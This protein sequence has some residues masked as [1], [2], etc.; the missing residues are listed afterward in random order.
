MHGSEGFGWSYGA[1]ALAFT[2]QWILSGA[3]SPAV[4]WLG[5]R[6]GVHRVMGLGAVLFTGGM[7]LTGAMTHLWQFLFYF[8]VILGAS[9]AIFQVS[10]ITGVTLWFRTHLGIAIGALQG[11]QGFGTVMALLLSLIH[12]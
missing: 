6:Y 8:G 3:L 7:L 1:I 12:I 11:F 9:M 2:V 5:D 4:G 10:L